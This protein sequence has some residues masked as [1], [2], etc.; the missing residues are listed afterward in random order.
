MTDLSSWGKRWN[1]PPAAIF[2]LAQIMGTAAPHSPQQSGAVTEAGVS[3]RIRLAYAERGA[4]LWRNNVGAFA[5]ET[6][7]WIRYGLANESKQMNKL[8][9]SSDLIGVM[10]V[11]ITLQHVGQIIGQFIA[12]ETKAPDWVFMGTPREWAQHKFHQ[13]V[14]SK[15]GLGRFSTGVDDGVINK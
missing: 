15:G 3:Q 14:I 12:I 13:I 6:G 1:I 8:V 7:R 4:A 10:P 9:K 11:T 5:D 2:E